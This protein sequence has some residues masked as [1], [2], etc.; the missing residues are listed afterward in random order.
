MKISVLSVSDKVEEII[1]S[2][3]LRRRFCDVEFVISC[4]DLPYY[5]V[6]YIVSALDKPVFFVRGN[7]AKILEYSDSGP[8]SSPLGAFDLH[9]KS[10]TLNGVIIAGIEGSIRY[11]TG[12]FQY[13]QRE[14]WL[15]TLSIVPKLVMNR[16]RFGRYLD[17][18]VSHAPPWQIN[19]RM[20]W[21]HQGIKS[22]RWLIEVFRPM[23]HFHGHIHLYGPDNPQIVVHHGTEV[24]NTYGHRKNILFLPHYQLKN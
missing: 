13:T 21:P 1:Y 16:A 22:F 7:H 17:I 2:P 8:R 11:N 3:Q 9:R 19:D 15:N 6:E 20:D 5:Y 18:F 10:Y 4:G 12:P 14:M 23:Y 24:V